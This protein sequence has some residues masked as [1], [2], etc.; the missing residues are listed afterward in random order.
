[1]RLA[2]LAVLTT[3][4]F[5]TGCAPKCNMN[6]C[7]DELSNAAVSVAYYDGSANEYHFRG[8]SVEYRPVKPE[9]SSSGRYS[10]GAPFKRPLDGAMSAKIANA[11]NAAIDAKTAQISNRVMLS[12]VIAIQCGKESREWIIA[13]GSPE[14]GAIETLM[15]ELKAAANKP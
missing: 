10:G 7:P 13:P 2:V 3:T 11:F 9:E 15:G 5:A 1:M 12:G 14:L 8:G 4:L 6:R